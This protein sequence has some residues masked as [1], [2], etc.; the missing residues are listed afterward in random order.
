M[1]KTALAPCPYYDRTKYDCGKTAVCPLKI[2]Q[3][4]ANCSD[5]TQ[6]DIVMVQAWVEGRALS[7][8]EVEL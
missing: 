3:G 6:T 1:V 4:S 7:R 5:L 2:I 8:E